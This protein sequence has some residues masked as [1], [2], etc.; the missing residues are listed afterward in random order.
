MNKLQFNKL[1]CFNPC[2]ISNEPLKIVLNINGKWKLLSIIVVIIKQVVTTPKINNN[3]LIL[4][5]K[6]LVIIILIGFYY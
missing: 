5:I 2:V 6:E 4:F 1:T 3:V